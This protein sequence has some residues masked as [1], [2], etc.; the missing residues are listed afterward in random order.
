MGSE[1]EVNDKIAESSEISSMDKETTE[2]PEK[3]YTS[4]EFDVETEK[5]GT[6][7]RIDEIDESPVES[8]DNVESSEQVSECENKDE[9]KDLDNREEAED[10]AEISLEREIEEKT[11]KYSEQV[12]SKDQNTTDKSLEG[13]IKDGIED[14]EEEKK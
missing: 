11:P 6:I 2:K 1:E 14:K 8:K 12:S 13:E 3:E 7:G 10:L 9:T 5:I 4:N